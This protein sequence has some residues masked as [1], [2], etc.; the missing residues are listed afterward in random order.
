MLEA[1]R[2][3]GVV[4]VFNNQ[5][6]PAELKVTAEPRARA[7]L[8]LL[9]EILAPHGLELTP[10]GQGVYAVTR[11]PD[12]QA[13]PER[14]VVA[15]AV[16][17][18]IVISTS[19]Y[20]FGAEGTG[21]HALVTA[22]AL[23]AMPRLGEE[24]LKAV[25]RLPGVAGNGVSGLSPVRGGEADE[26]LI[27]LDG[28]VLY[29]PFHLKNFLSPVSL[30]DS[31]FISGLD[32]YS[33]G[34]GAEFGDRMSAVID[35]RS[36]MPTDR[37]HY[38][39]GLSL[40]HVNGLAGGTFADDEGAWLVSLRQ[41]N[42]GRVL[43]AVDSDLGNPEYA[44]GFARLQYSLTEATRVSL[45][46]LGS[47]DDID[48]SWDRSG[49]VASAGYRN[50][51]VWTTVEHDWSET[52][53]G[54][55]IASFTDVDNQR[56]GVVDEPGWRAGSVVDVRSFQVGGINLAFT[57]DG[58][59]GLHEWGGEARYLEAQYAYAS[60]VR[61]EPTLLFPGLP[62]EVER[63]L[64][65]EP[66]GWKYAA[67]WSSRFELGYSW[68]TE[69]GLRLED[70][71]YT[72]PEH[73][74]QVGPRL[75]VLYSVSDATRI[76]ASWGRFSQSQRIN[77]LQV[78]DGIDT[79]LPAQ[80]AMHAV[81]SLDHAWTP[82]L[83]M[84]A[85]VYRKEY[86]KLKARSENLF[87]PLVLLPELQ[88]DRTLVAPSG[89]LTYGAE[90]SLS[91]RPQGE[92]SGWFSYSWSE[93]EDIVEGRKVLRSWDQKHAVSAGVRWSRGRWDITLAD[94]FHTGWPTTT[95]SLQSTGTTTVA[96]IGP[97]NGERLGAFN[98]VD[99]RASRRFDLPRGTLEAF[100][101]VTNLAS[102]DNECCIDYRVI[103]TP[104][105]PAL[106]TRVNHWLGVVP[107]VGVLWKY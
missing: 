3:S 34:F 8:P 20:A 82:A 14:T 26:T 43:S 66:S 74:V 28:L 90:L 98:S 102:K 31:R 95:V 65:A 55:V 47:R 13:A 6:V 49:E 7:G 58:F 21:S 107:S 30:L 67:Y 93:A 38:E 23:Q 77:E 85:E 48:L 15:P 73:S 33:G 97:R 61:F 40:F 44:D 22:E 54:K 46:L 84:R 24:S 17:E 78:E 10:V 50:A 72:G 12:P 27:L 42:L 68:A 4:V 32:F 35:T 64:A 19:R 25:Q 86:S 41:S 57:W 80:H 71:T 56:E 83:Q 39:L 91:W 52:L 89:A 103:P 100:V 1:T 18:E 101:E 62:T 51:Y 53:S 105:G 88:P 81:L 92:W 36:L 45:N 94:T 5:L 106:E 16:L 76:R 2:S 69:L 79:F 75:S 11:R 59:H 37:R 99:L 70:Q 87:D 60:R 63:N 9:A 104:A 96:V 29:E